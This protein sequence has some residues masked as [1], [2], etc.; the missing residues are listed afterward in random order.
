MSSAFPDPHDPRH[1]D[2]DVMHGLMA[3]HASES[4]GATV[5]RVE[6]RGARAMRPISTTTARW[7]RRTSRCFLHSGD[8]K[9][10]RTAVVLR[11]RTCNSDPIATILRV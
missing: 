8:G 1:I 2:D 10:D 11:R 6:P 4:V 7:K 5:G 3:A 9:L